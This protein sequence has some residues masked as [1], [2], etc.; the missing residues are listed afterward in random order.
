MVDTI[1]DCELVVEI[2]GIAA[3]AATAESHARAALDS[4]GDVF[5]HLRR[6][7]CVSERPHRCRVVKGIAEHGGRGGFEYSVGEI[8]RDTPVDEHALS[9]AAHLAGVPVG[10][11]D[12]RFSGRGNV[13]VRA[14]DDR[15]VA[16][17][18]H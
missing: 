5:I 2:G 9:G 14:D 12:R 6:G 1:D 11:E 15:T 16:R 3:R 18:L 13:R 10:A 7:R 4:I 8:R 17:R